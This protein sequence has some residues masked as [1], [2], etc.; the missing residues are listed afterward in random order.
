VEYLSWST[1]RKLT[2]K[3]KKK[4]KKDVRFNLCSEKRPVLLCIWTHRSQHLML[5]WRY[6]NTRFTR[7]PVTQSAE[8]PFR[9]QQVLGSNLGG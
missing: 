5:L 2:S 8:Y 9:I 7:L 3:K 1:N 4:K 6:P